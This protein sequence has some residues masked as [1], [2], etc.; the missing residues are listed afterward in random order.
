MVRLI[1]HPDMN[2]DVYRGRKTTVQ[3]AKST[4]M[5]WIRGCALQRNKQGFILFP[6]VILIE[7]ANSLNVLPQ[8]MWP[9][10]CFTMLC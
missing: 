9:I 1:D 6:I 8:P 4:N 3:N 5:Q 10:M 7:E 2:L